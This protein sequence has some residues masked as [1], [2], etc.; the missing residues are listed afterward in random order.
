MGFCEKERQGGNG[1]IAKH[2]EARPV[3]QKCLGRSLLPQSPCSIL[4]QKKHRMTVTMLLFYFKE[5]SPG[6]PLLLGV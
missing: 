3:K 4:P 2:N 1:C 6:V 5:F